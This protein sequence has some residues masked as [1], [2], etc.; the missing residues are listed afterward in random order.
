MT[1]L[2]MKIIMCPL[3]VIIASWILPNVAY[4]NILQPIIVGLILAVVG[5]LMEYMILKRGTLW[6]STFAD[7]V[8][9][10]II[11]Y[12]VS[13]WFP[14]AFVTFFGAL[15]TSIL[16]GV[17]EYFTHRWLNNVG[18]TKKSPT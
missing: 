11:V 15:L 17:I 18:L 3:A 13:N 5:V 6:I 2:L 12:F 4:E 16:L 1:S 14:G 7:A 8:A 10:L 9:S